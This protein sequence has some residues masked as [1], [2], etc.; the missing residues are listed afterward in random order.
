MTTVAEDAAIDY[1]YD[2]NDH[3]Y[4]KYPLRVFLLLRRHAQGGEWEDVLADVNKQQREHP[5]WDFTL[6]NTYDDWLDWYNK[7]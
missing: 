5:D 3:G 2:S 7:Q 1:L 4:F 6:T